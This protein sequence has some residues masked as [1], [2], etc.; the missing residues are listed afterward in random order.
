M[1]SE[2]ERIN[3]LRALAAEIAR[4]HPFL[5]DP[6]QADGLCFWSALVFADLAEKSGYPVQLIR[7]QAYSGPYCDHWAVVLTGNQLIDLTRSQLDGH[8]ALFWHTTDYSDEIFCARR[9]PAALFLREYRRFK[10][11][12][13]TRFPQSFLDFVLVARAQFDARRIQPVPKV[14][15]FGIAAMAVAFVAYCGWCSFA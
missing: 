9:Y 14:Q 6:A 3:A 11:Q 8:T 5:S 13:R 2:V 1:S 4:A 10:A 15:L 12:G 7:W